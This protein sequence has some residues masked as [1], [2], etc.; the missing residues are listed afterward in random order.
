VAVQVPRAGASLDDGLEGAEPALGRG[1]A[2]RQ[3]ERQGL[4]L[5][6]GQRCGLPGEQLAGV[7][8]AGAGDPDLLQ[9]V[10]QVG[11]GKV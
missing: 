11:L 10:F 4:G 7:R 6:A 9:D 2:P 5:L 8:G 1:A 3:V